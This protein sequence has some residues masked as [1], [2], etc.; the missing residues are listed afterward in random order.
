MAGSPL[1]VSH[2]GT[3]KAIVSWTLLTVAVA[4][5]AYLYSQRSGEPVY[6]GKPL[7]SWLEQYGTNHWSAGHGGA[8]DQQAEAALQHIGT[9][10]VPI[11][12]QMMTVRESPLKVKLL[13]LAQK[14]WLGPFH[15]PSVEEYRQQLDMRRSLGAY[16]FLALGAKAKPY[17][18][19]L[20]ALNTNEN[21][22]TRYF[23]IFALS[24]LGPAA[25]EALPDMIECLDDPDM[26]IRC[27]AAT[28]L[29]MVHQKPERSVRVLIAF[30]EK[31]CKDRMNW[32]PSYIA[33]WSLGQFGA[34]AKPAVPILISLL[35]DPHMSIRSAVTNALKKIDPDAAAKAGVK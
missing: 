15:G 18:P 14:P 24:R 6:Q 28:G 12:L 17:V 23:A 9:N 11:Y 5:L 7:T 22:R 13:T 32:P 20:I 34:Q 25:S 4:G 33:T 27:E 29:G 16:G 2:V 10:A 8:L 1:M 35:N 26:T 21:Q 30:L 19:V 3:C 31:Y